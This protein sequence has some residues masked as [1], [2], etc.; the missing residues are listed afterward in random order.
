M[1]LSLLVI[2]PLITT[3]LLL[4]ARGQKGVR[5]IALAGVTIQLV[6]SFVLLVLYWQERAAG[7]TAAGAAA[8]N[9]AVGYTRA[10]EA[11]IFLFQYRHAWF[12]A[13]H[14]DTMLASMASPSR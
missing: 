10:G 2:V 9:A 1:N 4:F 7:G 11:S 5:R 8:G 13:L 3:V 6:L 12:S 14:I